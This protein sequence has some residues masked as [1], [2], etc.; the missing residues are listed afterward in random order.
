VNP[1]IIGNMFAL[2]IVLLYS[3][4]NLHTLMTEINAPYSNFKLEKV[5]VPSIN[6]TLPSNSLIGK[7]KLWNLEKQENFKNIAISKGNNLSSLTNTECAN[8]IVGRTG[9]IE[10]LKF[11]DGKQFLFFGVVVKNGKRYVVFY[12]PSNPKTKIILLKEGDLLNGK[13][14][15]KK[16]G[17]EI[18]ELI[19]LSCKKPQIL[20]LHIFYIDI[21]DFQ[22]REAKK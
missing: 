15:V 10:F 7:P 19:P 21:K 14:K 18:L 17:E 20:R 11:P 12:N 8:Y 4:V 2:G 22:K 3:I 16:I 13:I 9:K 5:A 6:I 1:K